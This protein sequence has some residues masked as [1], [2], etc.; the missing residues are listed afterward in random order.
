MNRALK[1]HHHLGDIILNPNSDIGMDIDPSRLA[2]MIR[3]TLDL[4]LSEAH[5]QEDVPERV[6]A[7][8]IH[9]AT[10]QRYGEHYQTPGF[11]LR[12]YRKR[13]GLTQVQLA[14]CSGI[15]QHH[16]SEIENNKRALGKKNAK[17]LAK[18]LHCDYRKL[19]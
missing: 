7:N 16:L 2:S 6:P 9:E 15:L 1:I 12:L 18:I 5:V 4:Y 19:L 8:V 17:T 3:T 14:G 13:E 11:F 10:R